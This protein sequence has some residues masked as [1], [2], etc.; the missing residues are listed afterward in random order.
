M[1][2]SAFKFL[3]LIIFFFSIN[4]FAQMGGN[5]QE[6]MKATLE[7]LK[8]RLSLTD[9]QY[10]KVDSILK[11]QLAEMTKLRENSGGDFQS[12]RPAM[13]ELREKT[14]KK[15]EALLTEE[16]KQEYKKLL[17]ERTARRQQMMQQRGM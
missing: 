6:R 5:P 15:I 7:E 12:I 14:D 11:D 8:T 9:D 10:A 2:A 4:L 1:K 17:E 13:T 3:S 16:Q